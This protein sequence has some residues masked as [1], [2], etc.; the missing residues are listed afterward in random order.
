MLS[1]ALSPRP[2]VAVDDLTGGQVLHGLIRL[3]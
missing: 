2:V 1:D 3:Q